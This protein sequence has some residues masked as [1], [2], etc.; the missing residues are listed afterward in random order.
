[1]S[2]LRSRSALRVSEMESPT[3]G[4]HRSRPCCSA[5][6]SQEL[7]TMR[8]IHENEPRHPESTTKRPI[9]RELPEGFTA[10]ASI[11][12]ISKHYSEAQLPHV[13]RLI[14]QCSLRLLRVPA[15]ASCKETSG[16]MGAIMQEANHHGQ[17]LRYFGCGVAMDCHHSVLAR[18]R[19]RLLHNDISGIL[20]GHSAQLEA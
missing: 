5:S 18:G 1:M 16:V 8:T 4:L 14:G 13:C 17:L 19:T 3:T 7:S 15:S 10:L 2:S 11:K 20:T 12:S 6:H 9:V